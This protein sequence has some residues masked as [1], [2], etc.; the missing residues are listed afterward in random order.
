MR[1]TRSRR[2]GRCNPPWTGAI[3]SARTSHRSPSRRSVKPGSSTSS[4]CSSKRS[5]SAPSPAAPR[6]TR[7]GEGRRRHRR[8]AGAGRDA[9]GHA[10]RAS[11][12][13]SAWT[14]PYCTGRRRT[15]DGGALRRS[16][17]RRQ[18]GDPQPAPRAAHLARRAHHA[19][20]RHRRHHG[21]VQRRQRGLV[22]AAALSQRRTARRR[23]GQPH[24]RMAEHA[25]VVCRRRRHRSERRLRGVRFV[26][27][28]ERIARAARRR[29]RSGRSAVC[30]R[31]FVVLRRARRH[32]RPGPQLHHGR[33][34]ARRAGHGDRQPRFVAAAVRAG[35]EAQ[36]PDARARRPPSRH[37]RRVAAGVS[38]RHARPGSRGVVAA[39]A[40]CQSGPP[41]FARHSLSRRRGTAQR[42]SR[43]RHRAER[44]G[45]VVGGAGETVPAVLQG[46]RVRCHL[47][48]RSRQRRPAR[49]ISAL[50]GSR[51][52]R[53]AAGLRQCRRLA[54]GARLGT[55]TRNG[56]S[57]R[58]GRQPLAAR[59]ADARRMR[60]A[61]ID[62]EAPQAS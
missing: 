22:Q 13:G 27:G 58:A 11:G 62:G 50:V 37:R 52:L 60:G 3:T 59:A 48:R 4:R 1:S 46:P 20:D 39:V 18:D 56:H 16:A 10:W 30:D 47:A 36:W 9:R 61:V 42:R 19:R 51:G 15:R 26:D 21:A 7:R 34:S 28:D 49:A 35:D 12:S 31:V 24:T 6:T 45:G 41:L 25:V 8:L 57:Y 17:R 5:T 33:G 23:V 38:F 32:A 40:R 44:D 29:S 55:S 14:D 54:A 2:S 53:A 43:H